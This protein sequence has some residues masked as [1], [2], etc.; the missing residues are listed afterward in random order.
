MPPYFL[1]KNMRLFKT[2]FNIVSWLVVGVFAVMGLYV[3]SSNFNIFFGYQSFL[4]Q[5]GSMEPAIMTGDIIVIQKRDPYEQNDVVTFRNEQNRVVTHRLVEKSQTNEKIVFLTKGDANRSQDSDSITPG[6]IVGKVVFV[7]P[8]L[9]YLMA[10]SKSL[11]GLIILILIP[12]VLF[13]LDEL[14]K[15]KNA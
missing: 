7:I 4:V 8:K 15:I 13:I 9:G 10:F 6:Q 14:F 1:I 2:L 5:S 3:L 11:P 12:T